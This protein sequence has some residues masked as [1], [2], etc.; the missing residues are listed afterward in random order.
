MES[1]NRD[2]GYEVMWV[3]HSIRLQST[4]GQGYRLMMSSEDWMEFIV[5]IERVKSSRRVRKMVVNNE[6]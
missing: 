5:E 6:S 1:Q 2:L 3:S 4:N